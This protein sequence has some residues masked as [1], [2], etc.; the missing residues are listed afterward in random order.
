MCDGPWP[1]LHFHPA[2]RNQPSQEYFPSDW[3]LFPRLQLRGSAGFSPASL[4][5]NA[6]EGART[7]YFGKEQKLIWCNLL[8]SNGESQ[9]HAS[10]PGPAARLARHPGIL[11]KML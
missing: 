11:Y 10:C 4:L 8:V 9:L 7:K 6:D 3:L 5:I 1:V 2:N